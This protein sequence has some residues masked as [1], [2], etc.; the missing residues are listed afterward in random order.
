[1]VGTKNFTG[2]PAFSLR[3]WQGSQIFLEWCFSNEIW[4]GTQLSKF[5]KKRSWNF[6]KLFNF[7]W[8]FTK[9]NRNGVAKLCDL[10]TIKMH[11]KTCPRKL[12]PLTTNKNSRKNVF[13]FSFKFF[14]FSCHANYLILLLSFFSCFFFRSRFWRN[15]YFWADL[16]NFP[17]CDNRLMAGRKEKREMKAE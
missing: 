5:P 15:F 10:K 7:V 16:E 11:P 4:T 17:V 3:P 6:H 2:A 1:M 13:S 14:I 9:M 12:Y 8:V